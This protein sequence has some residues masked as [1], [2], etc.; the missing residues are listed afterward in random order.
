M[1]DRTTQPVSGRFRKR[2]VEV[3]AWQYDGGYH[4]DDAP[5]W[6]REHRSEYRPFRIRTEL[7]LFGDW[8][9]QVPTAEGVKGAS[10]G[11]LDRS[12]PEGRS[13]SVRSSS[14]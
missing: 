1:T 14:L 7:G 12:R 3:D 9:V 8:F 6:V 2:A 13:V 4:L 11:E 5:A 10:K